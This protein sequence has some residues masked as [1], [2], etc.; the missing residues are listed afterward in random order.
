MQ[1]MLSYLDD[2]LYEFLSQNVNTMP[3]RFVKLIAHYYTDAR[4]RKL[5]WNRLGISMGE[6]TFANLGLKL[7]TN[8]NKECVTIGN[9]V[10]IA[11]NVTFVA[12]SSANNGHEINTFE[13]VKNNLTK[14]ENITVED[15][16]WIGANVTIL[17][18]VTIGRCSVVGSGSVVIDDIEPYSI[19]VGTPAKKIRDLKTG[20]R[21]E[22]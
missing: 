1:K 3:L 2:K 5:Y 12:E 9:H 10:S 11:P 18:G 20:K 17:P 21:T 8:E 16:V 19:Y 6:G 4:I 14:A 13:Y 15:E 7:A 22:I